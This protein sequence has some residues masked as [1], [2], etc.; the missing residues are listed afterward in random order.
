MKASIAIACILLTSTASFARDH[1]YKKVANC[2][3]TTEC[4]GPKSMEI[5]L[6]TNCKTDPE[7]P[8]YSNLEFV[9]QDSDG[10]TVTSESMGDRTHQLGAYFPLV[11]GEE[12][13]HVMQKTDRNQRHQIV[14]AI[15]MRN[16]GKNQFT[17][18]YNSDDYKFICDV[19][20]D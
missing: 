7:G 13:L 8:C 15:S 6:T 19:I 12:K 14:G 17:G 11:Q 1:S 2:S 20:A 5:F 9:V 4:F 3:F 18:L 10:T 16:A